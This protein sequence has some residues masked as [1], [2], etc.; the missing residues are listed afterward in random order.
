MSHKSRKSLNQQA[1][2]ILQAKL[3]PGESKH[4][5]KQTGEYRQHIYSY[6]TY[7]NYVRW[8]KLFCRWCKGKHRCKTIEECRAYVDEYLKEIIE[9]DSASTAKSYAS[10]LAKLYGCSTKDFVPTPPRHRKDIKRSRGEAKRDKHFSFTNNADLVR[11]V[12]CTGLR[13]SELSM[14]NGDEYSF[15]N[16]ELYIHIRNGKGGKQ[17]DAKVVGSPEDIEF[18]L[19]MMK[20]AGSGRVFR[21]IH[22]AFDEHSYRA[23]YA[24]RFYK[25][26]ARPIKEIPREDRYFC[27][28]D[29]KGLVLDKAAMLEI[30]HSLGH[31]RIGVIASNYAYLFET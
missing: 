23:L 31:N 2:D 4:D 14:L 11:F 7:K 9:N 17:R 13:R 10:A 29:L 28:K 8:C 1:A 27:R 6:R 19:Q 5:A 30:S 24:A 15:I 12:S 18:V 20:K 16:G 22:S 21:K 25:Q 26:I 3:T